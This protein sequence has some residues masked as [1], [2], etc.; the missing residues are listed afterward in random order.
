M[1]TAVDY[2]FDLGDK[3][4]KERQQN[5]SNQKLSLYNQLYPQT[6]QSQIQSQSAEQRLRNAQ[7][8]REQMYSQ[9]P[10][11]MAGQLGQEQFLRDRYGSSTPL[12]Q[13]IDS[14]RQRRLM[15]SSSQDPLA[16]QKA[17]LDVVRKYPSDSVESRLAKSELRNIA[18]PR[19]GASV[20]VDGQT[21]SLGGQQ[22]GAP[23]FPEDF[24]N[25]GGGQG[26]QRQSGQ[27]G[28]IS[29]ITQPSARSR[30]GMTW[31]DSN[32]QRYSVESSPVLTQDQKASVA[33]QNVLDSLPDL[34]YLATYSGPAGL[35]S[36]KKEFGSI[37]NYFN[38]NE[39]Y[40]NYIR[41]HGQYKA[42]VDNLMNAFNVP[43]TN[44][45]LETIEDAISPAKGERID[46]Y[47]K[48]LNK[49]IIPNLLRRYHLINARIH[50]GLPVYDLLNSKTGEGP[51][52]PFLNKFD[53]RINPLTGKNFSSNKV[54][55][56]NS[57]DGKMYRLPADLLEA[58]I[59]SGQYRPTR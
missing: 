6:V 7:A 20:T 57:S 26:G 54:N 13:Y 30:A 16:K 45:G 22:Q 31:V 3:L 58:A 15:P 23:L 46:Q 52:D 19:Q 25:Q 12:G 44:K 14:M 24:H 41:A 35:G 4:A 47:E 51:K 18:A 2:Y 37:K 5:L 8:Q 10:E 21:V 39:D 49:T 36:I 59:A 50:K 42:M 55:V 11:L 38:N 9:H 40:Q 29:T 28:G 17:L 43:R 32:G 56:V 1:K 48:R 53:S 34:K 27:I 33:I